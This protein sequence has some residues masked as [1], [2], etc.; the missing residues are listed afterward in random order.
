MMPFSWYT[1]ASAGSSHLNIICFFF[2]PSYIDICFKPILP[3]SL[4]SGTSL[5]TFGRKQKYNLISDLFSFHSIDNGVQ[6]RWDNYTEVGEHDV[7]SAGDIVPKA[8]SKDGEKGRC[9]KHEDDTDM[10]TTGTKC[11]LVGILGGE[12][13]NSTENESVRNGNENHI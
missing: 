5:Y 9:I 2:N 8:M 11:L 7:E 4:H 12:V 1:K 13:K 3:F 10:R 6:C